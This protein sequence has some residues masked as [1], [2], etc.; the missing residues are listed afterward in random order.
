L[1]AVLSAAASAMPILLSPNLTLAGLLLATLAVLLLLILAWRR[2]RKRQL[3]EATERIPFKNW[4]RHIG[5]LLIIGIVC[6]VTVSV[7]IMLTSLPMI[8]MMAANWLDQIGVLSGDPSGMP[9][10]VKWLTLVVFLIA[11]FLQAYVWQSVIGPLYMM[12]GSIIQHEN[13]R[14]KF[15]KTEIKETYETNLIYRP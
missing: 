15:N 11:G 9:D 13:E 3:L 6:L 7:F 8:I 14:Q 12:R 1:F 5:M 4:L 2:L 10:Y